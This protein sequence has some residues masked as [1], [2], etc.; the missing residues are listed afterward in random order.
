ARFNGVDGRILLGPCDITTGSGAFTMSLWAKADFV[1]GMD[2]TLI[3]KAT[4]PSAADQVWSIAFV[5][6]SALRMRIR[7]GGQTHQ[8]TTPPSSLFGGQWYHIAGVYDGAQMRLYVNASLMGSAPATG[9]PGLHPQAPASIG[10]LSTGAQ[11]FSG[12]ID[13]VR[14]YDRAL[15]ESELLGI[16]FET[17]TTGM[18]DAPQGARATDRWI[19]VPEGPHIL[20]VM[21]ATGRASHQSRVR[22]PM[23]AE[24]PPLPS[25]VH[26]LWLEGAS[27]SRATRIAVP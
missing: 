3:A 23:R 20:R 10:A 6:G 7:T 9:L 12:W 13:D 19:D 22:G 5:S 1:T 25:G 4:G 21:D 14:V 18:A 27:G 15:S 11:P 24:L 2:R 8:L 26:F 17:L 16:L